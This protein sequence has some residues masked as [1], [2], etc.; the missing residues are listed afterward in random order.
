MRL[1]QH[2]GRPG[3]AV[4]PERW[5]EA[6]RLIV[7]KT[8]TGCGTLRHAGSTPGDFDPT[9]GTYPDAAAAPVY[10]TGACGIAVDPQFATHAEDAV[11]EPV[12]TIGYTVEIDLGATDPADEIRVGDLFRP[13]QL[14]G[15]GDPSLIGR[16]LTVTSIARG[17]L[18]WERVLGCLDQ[19]PPAPAE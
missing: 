5:S 4:I 9:T 11:D 16:D 6:P 15:N 14:D 13:A 18:T 7:G 2:T 3:T 10:W 1:V 12:T 19:N 8:L 17:S